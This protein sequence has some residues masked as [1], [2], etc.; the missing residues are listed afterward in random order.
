MLVSFL[1]S[2]GGNPSLLRERLSS[3]PLA[4]FKSSKIQRRSMIS[5]LSRD[6]RYRLP[7]S[8]KVE[9]VEKYRKAGLHP[10]HL[11]DTVKDGRYCI[12]HKL[13]FGGSST[14]W[15]ARDNHQDKLVSLKVLTA[16]ASLQRKELLLLR[17]LDRHSGSDLRRKSI[18]VLLDDFTIEGPNGVHLCH[19]SQIGG[20]SLSAISDSP[21]RIAGTRRLR[22]SLARKV[23]RQLV[24]AIGLLHNGGVVHGG[25]AFFKIYRDDADHQ[26][27]HHA[28]KCPLT[29]KRH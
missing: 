14:V 20:P 4:V 19:V 5:S 23:A 26:V 2:V 28:Q 16:Q 17:H 3:A 25:M 8:D 1:R 6:P 15:L 10:L 24:N 7:R 11:G 12:L 22:A 29:I 13:G 27:R 9:D 18:V 21:G